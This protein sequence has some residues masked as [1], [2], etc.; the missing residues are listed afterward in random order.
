MT[1]V[2]I[3]AIALFQ[4][5]LT[6]CIPLMNFYAESKA[7]RSHPGVYDKFILWQINKDFFLA[8]RFYLAE[9]LHAAGGTSKPRCMIL[10]SDTMK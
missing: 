8:P 5:D 1:S 7:S 3:Y 4:P 10:Q 6:F 2:R 9:D